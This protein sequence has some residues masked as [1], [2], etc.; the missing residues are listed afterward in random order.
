MSKYFYK[1]IDIST[2]IS[3]SN[4]YNGNVLSTLTNSYV[5][6]PKISDLTISNNNFDKCVRVNTGYAVNGTD[7]A[8]QLPSKVGFYGATLVTN[9]LST[10]VFL[11]NNGGFQYYTNMGNWNFNSPKN[12]TINIDNIYNSIFYHYMISPS[13]HH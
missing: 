8:N 5:G 6:F 4:P 7:I 13:A 3:T 2:I 12:Y 9:T 1:D 11:T 10:P